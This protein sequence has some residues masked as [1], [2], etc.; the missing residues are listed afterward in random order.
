[1]S[2]S[3]GSSLTQLVTLLI[4]GPASSSAQPRRQGRQKDN[5]AF[6]T[7]VIWIVGTLVW[8]LLL[9]SNDVSFDTAD[10]FGNDHKNLL[11]HR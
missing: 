7:K 4:T 11:G 8:Q 10:T 6:L 3:L 5:Y 2:S 9:T 1:M